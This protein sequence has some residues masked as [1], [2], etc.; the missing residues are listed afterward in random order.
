MKLCFE[1]ITSVNKKDEKK[2]KKDQKKKTKRNLIIRFVCCFFFIKKAQKERFSGIYIKYYL[3][4][5][6][7]PILSCYIFHHYKNLNY[8]HSGIQGHTPC[9]TNYKHTAE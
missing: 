7:N 4:A 1:P 5:F 9:C 8:Y 6:A 2:F 3:H